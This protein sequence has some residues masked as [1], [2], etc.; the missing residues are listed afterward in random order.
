MKRNP[1][2]IKPYTS[3]D[4]SRFFRGCAVN[5]GYKKLEL[6][7]FSSY[8]NIDATGIQDSIND[9]LEFVSTINL[10][11]LHRTNSEISKMNSLKEFISGA[12]L[13]YKNDFIKL[14]FHAIYQRYDKPL[15]LNLRPY[16]QYYFNGQKLFSMSSD[17]NFVYKNINF[18]GEVA[19]SMNESHN[20][21]AMLHGA[22]LSLDSRLSLGILYRDY[23]KTYQTFYNAGFSEG[24]KTQNENGLFT[25]LKF[26]INKSWS[27]NGYTDIFEFPWM[28][29]GVDAP[30]RGH[31]FL[32]QPIYK[33][34]RSFEIY[35]RFRQ[36]LRQKNSSPSSGVITVVED[37]IQRNYRLNISK[38][39]DKVI[40]LKSRL[41]IVHIKRQSR[42][43]EVGLLMT[44][45][46]S[47]RPKSFPV[48]LTLRYALFD[49]DSY[50][51]RIYSYENNALYVFSVPSYYYK[52]SRA[53]ILA[54]YSF[55]R[56]VD[57]W[58]RYG[59]FLYDNRNEIGSGAQ[60]IQGNRKTD[61]TIQ[62]KIS[63]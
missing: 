57:L 53:Y 42:E 31:E 28:K 33:P 48:D 12:S 16:N 3:V 6:L 43:D 20:G 35:G 34:S 58:I 13:N 9:N 37:V 59:F 14:G 38:K 23:D 2:P 49:T 45:D 11:G 41:E 27:I 56:S 25:G 62:L 17:Y 4:E 19:Y 54:R 24:S 39:I 63:L 32:I 18:F 10:S 21:L 47:W 15:N 26:K 40:T 36:Q 7:L 50:D 60:L 51:T 61:I 52:G 1:I 22:L 46:I 8:K 55:L 30:S 29:F 44:Q 5:L